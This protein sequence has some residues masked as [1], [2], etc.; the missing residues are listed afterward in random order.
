MH[1]IYSNVYELQPKGSNKS[2]GGLIKMNTNAKIRDKVYYLRLYNKKRI[3]SFETMVIAGSIDDA[4]E[5]I[6]NNIAE[7]PHHHSYEI[8]E[9]AIESIPIVNGN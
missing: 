2:C 4:K 9:Y 3:K 6:E 7:L 5:L 1:D 8:S